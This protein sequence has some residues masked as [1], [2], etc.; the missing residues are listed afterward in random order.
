MVHQYIPK[1][2]NSPCKNPPAPSSYLFNVGSLVLAPRG[3]WQQYVSMS[4]VKRK[5][6]KNQKA[7]AQ[8][9]K[10][11]CDLLARLSL[12]NMSK[13]IEMMQTSFKNV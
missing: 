10:I 9:N 13:I 5:K 1:I 2:F 12:E 11:G 6:K 4:Y 7:V 3:A 8:M